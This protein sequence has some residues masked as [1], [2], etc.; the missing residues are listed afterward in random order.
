MSYFQ[1][2]KTKCTRDGLCAAACPVDLI[3]MDPKTKEPAPVADAE[4]LCITCG[5]CVAVCPHGA[6]S[7]ERIPLSRCEP[8]PETWRPDPERAANFLKGRRSIR[9]YTSDTVERETIER[10]LD[11]ARFAPSGVNCQPLFWKVIYEPEQTCEIARLTVEWMK[12]LLAADAPLARALRME[13]HVR[14]WEAGHDRICRG[15]PHLII[16]CGLAEDRRAA[17][18]AHIAVTYVDLMAAAYNIGAC[19]AGYV[20]MAINESAALKKYVGLRSREAAHGAM[21]LGHAAYRYQ[22]I[23]VRKELNVQW[24]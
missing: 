10:I 2:D 14:A 21:M 13:G 9:R 5:H 23:P 12:T 6:L 11:V 15:A 20:T 24:M 19:W 3:T 22:R 18:S 17:Q 7:L 16:A 4:K 1:F 8:L